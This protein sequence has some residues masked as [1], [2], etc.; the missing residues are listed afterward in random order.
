M[1]ISANGPQTTSAVQKKD[2]GEVSDA[3]AT[4]AATNSSPYGFTEAQANAIIAL[5][6]DLRQLTVNAGL[7]HESA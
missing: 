6:N 1:T 4:T 3:V 5:V 7:C 2:Y